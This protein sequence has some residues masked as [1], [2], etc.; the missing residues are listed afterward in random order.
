[1]TSSYFHTF[2]HWQVTFTSQAFKIILF[3]SHGGSTPGI[4]FLAGRM[5][6][7]FVETP[8]SQVSPLQPFVLLAM[9]RSDP[10]CAQYYPSV[11]Y[12]PPIDLSTGRRSSLLTRHNVWPQSGK[13]GFSFVWP[14]TRRERRAWAQWTTSFNFKLWWCGD[15]ATI[16][17]RYVRKKE[18]HHY[19]RR[20]SREWS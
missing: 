1:M 12:V 15:H 9:L 2:L 10:H 16:F 13:G 19:K 11:S 20:C 5:S 4:Q 14:G 3:L 17:A 18:P 6:R 8:R 7:L